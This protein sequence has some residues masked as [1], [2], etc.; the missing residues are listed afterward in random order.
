MSADPIFQKT[1]QD[2][3][4]GIRS[5]KTDPSSYI[6]QAISESKNELK[7]TDTF[8][9]AEAIRKLTYIQ[10]L[11]Y[12][13]SWASF[14]IVEVMSQSRFAHKRVG[15]LAANQSFTEHTDV[16]L[17]TTNL[18]KKEFSSNSSS[19]QYEIGLAINCLA[20]IATKDLARDCLPDLMT[21]M[22]HS[23]PYIR[24]K[25]VLAMYKLYAQY[26]PGLRLTFD[27]MKEHLD[28]SESSVTSCAVN[29]ICELANKNPRN[30]LGLAPKLFRLLTTSSNNWMLIKVVKLLGSLVP[31]EPRLAR[32]LLEPLATIVENTGAKSLQYECIHAITE[33]L[34]FT[35]REDGSDVKSSPAIVK[36]C[37]DYLRKFIE[38]TDQN[39]KYLGLVG[40]VSL[41]RSHPKQVMD[42]RDIILKCLNDEDV[43]IRIKSLELLSGIVSKKSLIDLIN[44]LMGHIREAEGFYR[45]EIIAKVLY[46]CSKDKY[47]LVTDFEWYLSILVALAVI[48]GS[49]HGKEVSFQIIDISLRVESV[50]PYAVESMLSLLL[51]DSIILGQAH[52]IVAE[53]L[54]SAAWIVGEYSTVISSIADDIADDEDVAKDE[55]LGYWI[56]GPNGEDIRSNWR[57]QELHRL[58]IEA[59]LHPRVTNLPVHVLCA[60]IQAAIKIFIRSCS[61]C[62]ESE[63]SSIIG[64]LRYR[65]GIFLQNQHVEVQERASS[66]RHLMAEFNILD[67]NWQSSAEKLKETHSEDNAAD[68]ATSASA[69]DIDLLDLS[70]FSPMSL[71]MIDDKG[72]KEAKASAKILL[73]AIAEPFYPVHSKAQRRV[74]VPEGL[75][76]NAPIKNS[77]LKKLLAVEIPQ[78][79]NLT[80]L[81]FFSSP[82]SGNNNTTAPNNFSSGESRD[83]YLDSDM[84]SGI[85]TFASKPGNGTNNNNESS[86]HSHNHSNRQPE[87]GYELFYLAG[88]N[89][90][91]R[92]GQAEVNNPLSQLLA[93][94][95][96]DNANHTRRK[97]KH[98]SRKSKK[99]K[100]INKQ[101]M[102]P[103]GAIDSDDEELVSK[104]K[105]SSKKNKNRNGNYNDDDEDMGLGSVDLSTPL[106]ADEVLVAQKHRVVPEVQA[107]VSDRR[108][109]EKKHKKDK[110]GSKKALQDDNNDNAS[111]KGIKAKSNK[112]SSKGSKVTAPSSEVND[113]LNMDWQVQAPSCS[114]SA[115]VASKNLLDDEYVDTRVSSNISKH[116][117]ADKKKESSSSSR[118]SHWLSMLDEQGQ[119]L[120]ILYS[121]GNSASGS[122]S[123]TFRCINRFTDG[124]TIN[125]VTL[126]INPN[127]ASIRYKSNSNSNSTVSIAG[128]ITPGQES[129]CQ[130]DFSVTSQISSNISVFSEVAYSKEG[131]FLPEAM[132]ARSLFKIFLCSTF[133][134]HKI[135]SEAFATILGKSSQNWG[136]ASTKLTYSSDST[137]TATRFKSA[138][139]AI[140]SLLHCHIVDKEIG[141]KTASLCAKTSST[142][143]G[144]FCCMLK[145][146]SKDSGSVKV[147]VKCLSSSIAESLELAAQVIDTLSDL[148]L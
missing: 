111:A 45:D 55:E 13:I 47:S 25:S 52:Q 99:G 7:S 11:G 95:F 21:L 69:G 112:S 87:E 48:Q 15:Y 101:E 98:T 86:S 131:S 143:G 38:D 123:I 59:L 12:N 74:P 146:S 67:L 128:Q 133:N 104:H 115:V 64:V 57:G 46:M 28:D 140:A 134:A 5:H 136:S 75:D 89:G 53:V 135:N 27:K 144:Y 30:Y 34:P 36:L 56:E 54:K 73:S 40:L 83:N 6:S 102:L 109:K 85:D 39:L 113:L 22:N 26:P 17:L 51:D 62:L 72:A 4:K 29:V 97:G 71:K 107:S 70:A 120:K 116:I 31:E 132:H 60:Y 66:L 125:N 117:P 68:K 142:G 19:N 2:L 106:R 108:T 110:D 82:P 91:N 18:F 41:L 43:T 130:I 8:L 10:M 139:K 103:A 23:K 137:T 124:S 105:K 114:S 90:N 77:A 50:R 147:D 20:N 122:I 49:R 37:S 1:L 9:K 79:L 94:S 138:V 16:I 141:S 121:L 76:I 118:P 92:G 61:D 65:L 78:N 148:V 33:A 14:A 88:N 35:K 80:S 127:H 24:K 96:E 81:S 119:G 84:N 93:D 42:H 100:E 145:S 129:Q 63:I 3:V 126:A 32:K 44:H 58:V